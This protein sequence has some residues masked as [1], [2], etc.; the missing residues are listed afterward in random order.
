MS[1]GPRPGGRLKSVVSAPKEQRRL[2]L[3]GPGPSG[4]MVDLDENSSSDDDPV[5]EPTR[6]VSDR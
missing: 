3:G 2:L 5:T 4:G 1:L 6:T